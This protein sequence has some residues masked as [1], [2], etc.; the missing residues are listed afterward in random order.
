MYIILPS[1]ATTNIKPSR[2]WNVQEEKRN[3][4]TSNGIS[5]I[6]GV[7]TSKEWT[8]YRYIITPSQK[9]SFIRTGT[10]LRRPLVGSDA[11]NSAP[12]WEN[13]G[14]WKESPCFLV[15]CNVS[16]LSEGFG[17]EHLISIGSTVPLSHGSKIHLIV[18]HSLSYRQTNAEPVLECHLCSRTTQNNSKP[19]GIDVYLLFVFSHLYLLF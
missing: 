11:V 17:L 16:S 19:T 1:G 5:L 3:V 13:Q 7:H 9:T 10:F 18:H 6:A 4:L 15:L 12:H 14:R 2:V 8:W